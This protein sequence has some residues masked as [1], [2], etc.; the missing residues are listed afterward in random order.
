M[1]LEFFI[2]SLELAV[3]S[4]TL[5]VMGCFGAPMTEANKTRYKR[6][7]SY[8]QKN[9]RQRM[10]SAA[11]PDT[12]GFDCVNL[13]KGI[14]WGWSGDKTKTYGG[15]KYASNGVPDV[16]ADKMITLCSKVSDFSTRPVE[17]GEFVWL[18]GHCGV[19]VG[20]GFVIESSP[21]WKNGVQKTK[22]ADR[23][24]VK[25]GFLPWVEYEEDVKPVMDNVPSDWAKEA[26]DWCVAHGFFAGSDTGDFK[27]H[28]TVTRQE[29]AQVIYRAFGRD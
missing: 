23:V 17:V 9:E 4:K 29:L 11:T 19:Y 22:L 14:L 3:N 15:A 26:C 13:V 2:S 20:D 28:S 1:V 18:P 6:N 12:F 8:N 25:H 7:H 21:A 16:G 24:W 27:W 10:I 5:Y